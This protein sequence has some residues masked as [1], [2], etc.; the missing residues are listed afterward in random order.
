MTVVFFRQKMPGVLSKSEEVSLSVDTK[1][2]ELSHQKD[3]VMS[4]RGSGG[5]LGLL[6]QEPPRDTDS[7]SGRLFFP[8]SG[9]PTKR[10]GV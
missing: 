1:V 8:V 2:T 7:W 6:E 5:G 10:S 9:N 4:L 3:K